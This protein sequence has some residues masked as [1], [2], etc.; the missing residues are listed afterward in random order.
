MFERPD[1]ALHG[2]PVLAEQ[3]GDLPAAL[4]ARNQQQAMQP[5]VVPGLLGALDLLLDGDAHHVYVSNLKFPHSGESR[6]LVTHIAK[7][8]IRHYLCRHI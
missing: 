4:A 1:P 2:A 8:I 7:S 5:T 6:W 3:L